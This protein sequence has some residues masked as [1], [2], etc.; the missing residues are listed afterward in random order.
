[1]SQEFW[2]RLG[3]RRLVGCEY[4]SHRG[5]IWG[6]IGEGLGPSSEKKVFFAGNDVFWCL[7]M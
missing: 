3:W 6:R 1:M 5:C 2:R 4:A 7:K